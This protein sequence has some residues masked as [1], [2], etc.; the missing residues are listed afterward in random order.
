MST[1]N[2]SPINGSPL[3]MSTS[4][5]ISVLMTAATPPFIAASYSSRVLGNFLF[6]K[7]MPPPRLRDTTSRRRASPITWR[8]ALWQ[9]S[10]HT[11]LV[12]AG[13]HLNFV[14]YQLRGDL[15]AAT[16]RTHPASNHER[17]S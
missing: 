12:V 8:Y 10:L 4:L 3:G 7:I 13:R 16:P 14:V 1:S 11:E 9:R 15:P 6:P 17:Y 2:G 5:V